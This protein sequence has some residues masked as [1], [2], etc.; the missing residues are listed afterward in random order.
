MT[1]S[2]SRLVYLSRNMIPG[3]D[4]SV[5]DEINQI[6]ETS[7]RNNAQVG[8]TGAL[9][10]NAGCFTQ[11]LEG[12]SEAVSGVFERIQRDTRHG[13]VVVLEFGPVDTIDFADWSM[14]FVGRQDEPVDY[15]KTVPSD[16]AFDIDKLST[17]EIY[18]TVYNLMQ[19]DQ[20]MVA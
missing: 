15:L 18:Q 5:E 7:R 14:G 8:V 11:I 9:L 6:L 2:L 13:D 16:G 20:T 12:P 19:E 17:R 1:Q 10:Y 4:V 3:D